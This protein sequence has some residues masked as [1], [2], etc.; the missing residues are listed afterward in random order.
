MTLQVPFEGFAKAAQT[1][2]STKEVFLTSHPSGTVM[3]CANPEKSVHVVAVSKMPPDEA[4]S[5][6]TKEG[7]EVRDG[8]WSEEGNVELNDD[9]LAT[10]FVAAVSYHSNQSVPGVWVDAYPDQPNHVQVLRAMYEEF[11]Q[12]GEVEDVTF[13]EFIRLS[14]PNV[15]VVSATELR[16]YLDSKATSSE[17]PV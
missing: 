6:L 14:N 9:P 8:I 1:Y 3:T 17:R 11:R 15:V 12:T 4:R 13:E 2:A 16:S 5:A 10:A 7:L